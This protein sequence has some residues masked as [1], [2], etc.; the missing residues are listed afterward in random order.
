MKAN[1]VRLSSLKTL[2]DH[3]DAIVSIETDY[4]NSYGGLERWNSGHI[5]TLRPSAVNKIA[6]I[7]A[8]INRLFCSEDDDDY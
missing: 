2:G 8:R 6:K 3:I 7:E 5:T 1:Q 4:S